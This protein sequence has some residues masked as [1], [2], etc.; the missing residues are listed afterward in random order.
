MTDGLGWP[1]PQR[2]AEW[3]TYLLEWT[4]WCDWAE[5]VG[6]G[7]PPG[8][9]LQ[10]HLPAGIDPEDALTVQEECFWRRAAELEADEPRA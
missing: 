7:D 10:A 8:A 6:T 9:V 1:T 4:R 3:Q 2:C 5:R